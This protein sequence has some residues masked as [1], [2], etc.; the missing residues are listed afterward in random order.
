MSFHAMS[1]IPIILSTSLSINQSITHQSISPSV[2][3]SINQSTH[4]SI[5]KLVVHHSSVHLINL[6]ITSLFQ[7]MGHT[8]RPG[9]KKSIY[10]DG[11]WWRLFAIVHSITL[12]F[13]GLWQI[14]LPCFVFVSH[15][16]LWMSDVIQLV[17]CLM[18]LVVSAWWSQKL[19]PDGARC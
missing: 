15:G 13:D 3:Q 16:F 10:L 17:Q 9:L 14:V 7:Y 18:T 11:Y 2:N 6:F 8:M 5:S 19:A 1:S 4:Q 12:F